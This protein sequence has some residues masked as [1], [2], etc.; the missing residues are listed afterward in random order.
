MIQDFSMNKK[1]QM[2][3]KNNQLMKNVGFLL[4]VSLSENPNVVIL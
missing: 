4:G 2:K 1:L 3:Q